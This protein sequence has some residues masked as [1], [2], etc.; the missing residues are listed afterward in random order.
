MLSSPRNT[1][2]ITPKFPPVLDPDFIA[3]VLWTKAYE[4]K[5]AATPGS[6]DLDIAMVRPDG[7]CFR[8]HGV[9]LPHEGEENIALNITYV[10][11]VVK[12]LIWMK[13]G[14]RVMVAGDDKIAATIADIYSKGVRRTGC[15]CCGF[16]AHLEQGRFDA[17]YQ[18]YPKMYHHIM[19]YTNNGVIFREAIRKVLAVNGLVL[20]DEDR[21]LKLKFD[22]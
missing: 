15:V 3:P 11:R 9:V 16:G 19:A 18:L 14:S 6:H 8:W 2:N 10:E 22:D 21:Q 7:T 5:V 1:M 12:F 20:P 13:G 17:L 4:A